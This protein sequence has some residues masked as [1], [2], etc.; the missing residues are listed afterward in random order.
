MDLVYVSPEFK[1]LK[2]IYPASPS[3]IQNLVL[4]DKP[5]SHSA[6]WKETSITWIQGK[7]HILNMSVPMTKSQI[8]H[9]LVLWTQ[10]PP[11]LSRTHFLPLYREDIDLITS[12]V[13]SNSNMPSLNDSLQLHYWNSKEKT[14]LALSVQWY[15]LISTHSLLSNF[16]F[17]FFFFFSFSCPVIHRQFGLW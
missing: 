12:M 5:S 7:K 14:N 4:G 16:F 2:A 1:I 17:F 11:P 3:M 9:L 10:M 8:C 13:L 6:C 15:N